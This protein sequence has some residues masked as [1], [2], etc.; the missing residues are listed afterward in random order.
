MKSATLGRDAGTATP[1]MEPEERGTPAG[2]AM[3]EAEERGTPA[4]APGRWALSC[5]G[6]IGR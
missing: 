4:G 5:A 2:A 3:P 1:G 6:F